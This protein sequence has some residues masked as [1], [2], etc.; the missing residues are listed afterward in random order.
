MAA[1]A[2]SAG[3]NIIRMKPTH[4]W[5]L[6]HPTPTLYNSGLSNDYL[7]IIIRELGAR[8]PEPYLSI[9]YSMG[10]SGA[11]SSGELHRSEAA[12]AGRGRGQSQLIPR[13]V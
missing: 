2:F 7:A 6:D 9:G 5:G 8:W 10:K 1:K 11:K 3:F 13:N 12:L 4:L